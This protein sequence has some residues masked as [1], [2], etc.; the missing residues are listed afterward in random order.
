MRI[1]KKSALKF[2]NSKG[3]TSNISKCFVLCFINVLVCAL[4]MTGC[5]GGET[6]KKVDIDLTE[7]SAT[8]VYSNVFDM[9]NKPEDYKGKTVK[10]QGNIF[11]NYD[12]K[13]N[14]I[15]CYCIIAD[16]TACCSQGL[17]F[18]LAEEPE[19]YPRA[20]SEIIVTGRAEPF[21]YEDGESCIIKDATF[22]ER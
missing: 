18:V 9:V 12:E 6:S 10:M 17:E 1:E 7:M 3:R 5:S 4:L 21:K 2:R 13:D 8:M 16:A 20:D 15:R 11:M 22:E 19:K 14:R